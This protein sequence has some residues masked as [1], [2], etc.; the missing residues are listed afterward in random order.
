MRTQSR[1]TSPQAE[2]VLIHLIRQAPMTKRFALV[3]SLTAT[4]VQANMRNIQKQYPNAE[5]AE[6]AQT[7]LSYSQ[8]QKFQVLVSSLRDQLNG[9][10]NWM[11]QKPDVL[12]VLQS[13]SE[14][15]IELEMSYYIGGSLAS[16][17]Y[18]MQQ[19]TQDIDIIANLSLLQVPKLVAYLNRDYHFDEQAIRRATQMHTAFSILHLDTLLKVDIIAP[20]SRL[21]E[22]QANRKIQWHILDPHYQPFPLSS[23]EDLILIKLEQ[24]KEAGILPDD[25]WNDIL[26]VLKVQATNL[27]L[28]YLEKWATNLGIADILMQ[29]YVDAGLKE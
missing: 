4:T 12:A 25:Q 19:L 23:P 18:G 17:L 6:V 15:F 11:L 27:D 22:Q 20:Q 24:H 3:R 9:R 29:A 1:D 10:P 26:G 16:S 28:A 5:Q 8:E 21:F 2:R 13:L 14:I 7:F